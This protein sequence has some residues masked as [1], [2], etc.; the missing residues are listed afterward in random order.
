MTNNI[1]KSPEPPPAKASGCLVSIGQ[2]AVSWILPCFSPRFY[3]DAMRRRARQAVGFFILFTLLVTFWQSISAANLI[4]RA[5]NQSL[6][7]I[8]NAYATGQVPTIV[9]SQGIA[10]VYSPQPLVLATGAPILVAT[11][12]AGTLPPIDRQHY[13]YG[14]VLTR[15]SL[16]V[17]YQGFYQEL[18]L[19]GLQ[20]ITG[21]DPIVIVSTTVSN[22]A[23]LLATSAWAVVSILL[24]VWN[25]VVQFV[26]VFGVGL[27]IAGVLTLVRPVTR[28]RPV[29]IAGLYALVPA[30]YLSLL[31]TGGF[32]Y[33]GLALFLLIPIWALALLLAWGVSRPRQK[34]KPLASP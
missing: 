34:L 26:F 20:R 16:H 4:F 2:F 32:G 5:T 29:L 30:T 1:E 15:T 19:G 10:E 12:L 17:W 13:L 27:L 31:L 14:C 8:A 9:I 28:F 18:S 6:I 24:L 25:T 22:Y 21:L 7:Y 11:D 3:A 33:P 23:I